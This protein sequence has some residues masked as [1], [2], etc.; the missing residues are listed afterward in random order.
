V[1]EVTLARI[2][3]D[4]GSVAESLEHATRALARPILDPFNLASEAGLIRAE[5]LLQLGQTDAARTALAEIRTALLTTADLL[6][7]EDRT[8]FLEAVGYNAR[9][10]RLAAEVN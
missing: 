7:E 8:S 5:A 1:A 6:S 2:L 4:R 3:L 9:A 10:L